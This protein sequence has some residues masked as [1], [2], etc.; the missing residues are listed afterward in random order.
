[1][2]SCSQP[3]G[4]GGNSM[5]ESHVGWW[6]WLIVYD[7]RMFILIKRIG[8]ENRIEFC[9]GSPVLSVEGVDGS[10]HLAAIDGLFC[11]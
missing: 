6:R 8:E 9:E 11:L 1:M 10:R 7:K 2:D 5:E 3:E 4:D